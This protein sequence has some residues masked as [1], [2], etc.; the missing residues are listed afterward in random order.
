MEGEGSKM[1]D[2]CVSEITNMPED[3]E[4]R[5]PCLYLTIIL[6]RRQGLLKNSKC[7]LTLVVFKILENGN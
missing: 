2:I 6:F 7:F 1:E 5:C 4:I 3:R